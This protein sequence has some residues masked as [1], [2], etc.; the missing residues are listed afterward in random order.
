LLAGLWDSGTHFIF[1]EL[2]DSRLYSFSL[3][4]EDFEAYHFS[5]D[6]SIPL[7]G[8]EATKLK[9]VWGEEPSLAGTLTTFP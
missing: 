5:K 6:H 8:K 2:E 3:R 9:T 1:H 4:C 7:V